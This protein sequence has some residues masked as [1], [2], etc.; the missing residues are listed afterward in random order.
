M[1]ILLGRD[2]DRFVIYCISQI[3]VLPLM[4]REIFV[5]GGG[6]GLGRKRTVFQGEFIFCLALDSS[7]ALYQD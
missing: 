2:S 7:D 6:R 4:L 5:E 3:V 1:A